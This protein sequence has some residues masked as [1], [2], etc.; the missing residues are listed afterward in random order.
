MWWC[1]ETF[2]AVVTNRWSWTTGG[3]CGP[4]GWGLLVEHIKNTCIKIMIFLNKIK[5]F[6]IALILLQSWKFSYSVL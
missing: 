3:P 6:K 5:R 1:K 2:G 4:E